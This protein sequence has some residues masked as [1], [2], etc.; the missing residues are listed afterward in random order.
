MKR[1]ASLFSLFLLLPAISP[2]SAQGTTADYRRAESFLPAQARKLVC[3]DRPFFHWTAA[4][5][6]GWYRRDLPGGKSRFIWVDVRRNAVRP[7]FD[8]ARLAAALSQALGRAQAADNLPFRDFRFEKEPDLIRFTVADADWLCDLQNYAC[9]RAPAESESVAELRSPD[10]KWIVFVRDHNL[11]VR[12]AAGGAEIALTRDG[13]AGYAY[14]C[15]GP[16]LQAQVK[17]GEKPPPPVIQAVWSPDSRKLLSWR[18]DQRQVRQHHLLQHAPPGGQRARLYSYYYEL[19]GDPAVTCH[20]PL[21]FDIAARTMTRIA[22]APLPAP[23]SMWRAGGSG[24]WSKDGSRIYFSATERGYRTLKV[25]EADPASG[26]VR[27]LLTE[28]SPTCIDPH[29]TGLDVVSGG[30]ELLW[31]SERDGWC[32]LYRFSGASGALLNAVTQSGYVVRDVLHVDEKARRVYFV[33]GGREPGRDPYLRHLYRVDFD[34]SHLQLLTP[35]AADHEVRVA[36]DGRSFVDTFSTI[37]TAPVTV[38]RR[39]PDGR[40]LRELEKADIAPLLVAGW[41]PPQPFSAVGRDGKTMIYGA[42]YRP[43][44]FDP[45]RRYPVIDGIYNGPQAVRTPKSFQVGSGD[46]AL[47]ELGFIVVTIDGMGTAMRS[48][49]FHDVSYQNLGD[50]GLEDHILVIR[51]LAGKHPGFDLTRV[52]IYGHSAGGYDSAHAMLTHPEFYT[53]AVSSGGCHDNRSDKV[54]WNELWMGYPVGEHYQRQANPTLAANLRGKL[55]LV[56]GD[57]DDNVHPAA[58]LQLVD[59]LIK[60]NKDFDM[61]IIPNRHHALGNGYFVRKRWDYFVRHL[62]GVEPPAGYPLKDNNE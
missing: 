35:E 26:A 23:F 61:L 55:L 53:V 46:Q 24:T 47:A 60:A 20:E 12:P 4:G 32:R 8:H 5:D 21:V 39:L 45:A 43:S 3:N 11:Y 2:L 42:V 37:D 29:M 31:S 18:I 1:I 62:L 51:Q 9:R 49:A 14:G 40:L 27:L 41:R 56:H 15:E 13:C 19:P 44:N 36:P 7:A 25:Y 59:A 54:W 57:L 33:A 58:T 10:K 48:K 28:T 30:K 6:A 34:G 22:T 52:G 17:A 38:L 16:E 50:S